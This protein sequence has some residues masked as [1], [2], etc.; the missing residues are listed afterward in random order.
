MTINPF[1]GRGL[2]RYTRTRLRHDRDAA[3]SECQRYKERLHRSAQTNRRLNEEKDQLAE[4]VRDLTQQL[5]VSTGLV[6]ARDTTIR[7]LKRQAN[8][9]SAKSAETTQNIP[10]AELPQTAEAP[11]VPAWAVPD[12]DTLALPVLADQLV[13]GVA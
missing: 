1:A 2:R 10:R 6:E 4:Q 12:T 5:D 11:H 8:D 3:R 13:Q 7:E 9:P